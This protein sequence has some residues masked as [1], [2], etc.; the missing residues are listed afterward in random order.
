VIQEATLLPLV[1]CDVELYTRGGLRWEGKL[2]RVTPDE[3][4]LRSVY[5]GRRVILASE[6]VDSV[7]LPEEE[8]A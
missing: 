5:S 6:A 7:F 1:G 8:G 2:L 3:V 4:E